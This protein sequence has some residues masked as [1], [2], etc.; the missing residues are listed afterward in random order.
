MPNGATGEVAFP[1]RFIGAR[2][3]HPRNLGERAVA[4]VSR[5]G[6]T[7]R[8]FWDLK[9]DSSPEVTRSRSTRP[10]GSNG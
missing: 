1:D 3:Q 9:N 2:R 5:P 10:T 8:R 7:L 6:K 4:V